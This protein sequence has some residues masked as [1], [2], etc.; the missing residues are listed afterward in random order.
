MQTDGPADPL[1]NLST[2]RPTYPPAHPHN[3]LPAKML[4]C[5]SLHK[6]R[7]A[8]AT[9]LNKNPEHTGPL[10]Q[11]KQVSTQIEHIM[12]QIPKFKDK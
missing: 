1:T 8:P 6:I 3:H 11:N 12:M 4:P 7:P 9:A 5:L 2:Y 10:P